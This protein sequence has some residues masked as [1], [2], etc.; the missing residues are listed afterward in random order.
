MLN[1]TENMDVCVTTVILLW[2]QPLYLKGFKNFKIYVSLLLTILF[3]QLLH[4][5]PD[6]YRTL[7]D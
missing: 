2:K 6:N 3:E 5:I 4:D 7:K 1:P